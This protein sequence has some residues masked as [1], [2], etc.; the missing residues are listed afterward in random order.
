MVPGDESIKTDTVHRN[1]IRLTFK[2]IIEIGAGHGIASVQFQK[3][4]RIQSVEKSDQPRKSPL[5]GK[6]G[7]PVEGD[8]L[9]VWRSDIG[10]AIVDMRN[11]KLK[12]VISLV[13]R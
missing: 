4:R 10:V 6:I 1:G 5:L 11:V 8:G 3:I 7:F 13:P 2:K 12:R 9:H